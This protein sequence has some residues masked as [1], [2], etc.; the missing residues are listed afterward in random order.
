MVKLIA[1]IGHNNLIG[2]SNTLPWKISAELQFFKKQTMGDYILMGGNTFFGLPT[3]LLGRKLF[4]FNEKLIPNQTTITSNADLFKLFAKFQ[5][6]N[7]KTLWIAGGKY[8]YEKFF[9]HASELWISE[10]KNKNYQGDVYINWNLSSFQKVFWKEYEEF[11]VYKYIK[12]P[13]S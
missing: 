1:A 5:E 3:K 12:K 13:R 4:I 7:E 10:I 8:V 9:N 11:V 6:D 2:S